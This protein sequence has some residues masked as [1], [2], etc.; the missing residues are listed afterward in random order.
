MAKSTN[1]ILLRLCSLLFILYASCK[2]DNVIHPQKKDIVETVY[3]SGKILADSEYYTYALS[4]GTI[5]K[6]LVKE[7][8]LVRKGQILYIVR[9]DAP[10][11]KL[12][13][14]RT[15][16]NIAQSNLSDHSRVLNDLK[17][18]MQNAEVRFHNDSL[19]YVRLKK[20]MAADIGTQNNLDNAYTSYTISLNLRKSAEEKYFSAVNDL[21]A[22]LHN[23][24]SQLTSARSDLENYIIRSNANGTVYQTFKEQG[25]AVRNNDAVALLGK[26]QNRIIRLSVDQQD[27][28]KIQPG[29]QVL[30][31]T[32]VTENTIYK[33]IVT[34][35]YPV[36]NEADQTFRVDAV[37]ADSTAQSYIHS[38]IEANIIIQK[39]ELALIIPKDALSAS[40]SVR[41]IEN[42]KRK[43]V[44]VRTGIRTLDQVEILQGLNESSS[45]IMPSKK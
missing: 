45:V 16:F 30:L 20:L 25:E 43:T 31:K 22:N 4:S 11:A 32:D 33:A 9:Y 21:V 18:S 6:K 15:N 44:A 29:Q 42:K 35:I 28:D 34:R 5:E 10:A 24:Q 36:M 3:A 39:K 38:S 13:A 27:I 1:Q 19:Q 7:G 23:T 26:T 12:N 40:D 37:F 8:D 41:I 17:L 14:A 2:R